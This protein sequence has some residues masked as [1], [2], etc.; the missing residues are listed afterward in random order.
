M[1]VAQEAVDN[2]QEINNDRTA[3]KAQLANQIAELTAKLAEVNAELAEV[4]SKGSA[5]QEFIASV[6]NFESR[7]VAL[8]NGLHNHLLEKI[9]QE[10]HEAP[11]RELPDTLKEGVRFAVSRKGIKSITLPTFARLHKYRRDQ[12]ND[13][14]LEQTMGRVYDANLKIEDILSPE[15]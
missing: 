10:R 1:L 13:A 6:V 4:E 11:F 14:L 9:S 5:R 3:R 8:G 2:S 12:I 15:K 7:A